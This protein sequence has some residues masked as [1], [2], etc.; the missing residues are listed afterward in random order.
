MNLTAAATKGP[1]NITVIINAPEGDYTLT[2]MGDDTLTGLAAAAACQQGVM[3][4]M[5]ANLS[6]NI[7]AAS[8]ELHGPHRAVVII[9]AN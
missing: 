4:P 3:N 7:T 2:Y 9:P 5:T 8:A 1:E 6:Y